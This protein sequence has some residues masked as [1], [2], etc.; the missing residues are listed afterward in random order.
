MSL[1]AENKSAA[2]GLAKEELQAIVNAIHRSQAV[3]E[4]DLKGNILRANDNFCGAIGYSED[5]IVGQHHRMFVEPQ[6]AS[7]PEYAKFWQT[8]GSGEVSGGEFKRIAKGGREIWIQATYNPIFDAN[9]N[10]TG[11]VKFATDITET[12]LRNAN[13]EAQLEAI[14]RSQAVIEFDLTGNILEA[15]D[16]FYAAMGY[17]ADEIIGKHHRM[18]ATPDYAASPE[19]ADLWRRLGNGEFISGEFERVAKGGREIWLQASYNPIYDASGKPYKVVKFATDIT[20]QKQLAVETANAMEAA[21]GVIS[22]LA[23][24]DLSLSM[25]GEYSGEFANLQANLNDCVANLNTTVGKI[26]SGCESLTRSTAEIAQGNNDL[27][28]RTEEQAANLEETAASMEELTSTV[29]QNADNAK[30]ANQ[31]ATSARQEAENGGEVVA[32]AI[33]AMGAINESS[34]EISDIIGVIQEIAFQ[35]NLLA[36]NAAVEA[37]R[38]G[39]QGRGFAVVAS[40]VRNLAQRSSSAAKDITGLIKDSVAKVEDGSRLV[41]ETGSTLAEIVDSV[42][43][44]GDIIAEITAA[45]E[46]QAAGINEVSAAVQQMDQVTQSN[47]AMV[48]EAAA[49]SD[50]MDQESRQ[51]V[52]VVKYFKLSGMAAGAEVAGALM[53]TSSTPVAAKSVD[54]P[55]MPP[56]Q[57]QPAPVADD[58]W[59][60]F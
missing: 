52:D 8:L 37:A 21:G 42:N 30:Q 45:S 11:V 41:G 47:A 59:Q 48:E 49:A 2:D 46:E 12:K 25:E 17:T 6:Y 33:D 19:Y 35:T 38:A 56:P 54:E 22:A 24:G 39:E 10:P 23:Q 18:F 1:D 5:E 43:K 44:V 28:Q 50:N 57:A 27:S 13:F 20:A 40:E 32:R 4:F 29:Q 7:S 16:N 34:K 53:G 51:L 14:G 36:L 58:T 60:S 26:R 15:N 3:I 9:G 55:V 31:L